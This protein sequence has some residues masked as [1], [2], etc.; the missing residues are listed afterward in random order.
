M[1]N[2]LR[3]IQGDAPDEISLSERQKSV[4]SGLDKAGAGAYKPR[5]VCVSQKAPAPR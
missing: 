1:P 4:T 3:P 2:R 5:T